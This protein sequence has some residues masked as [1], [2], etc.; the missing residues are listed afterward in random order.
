MECFEKKE[1]ITKILL[2]IR[3]GGGACN[4]H[5]EQVLGCNLS[6]EEAAVIVNQLKMLSSIPLDVVVDM[7]AEHLRTKL[8][9]ENSD[10]CEDQRNS[11][12]ELFES[13]ADGRNL[14]LKVRHN[15]GVLTPL[16][17]TVLKSAIESGRLSRLQALRCINNGVEITRKLEAD[18]S[19]SVPLRFYTVDYV[20]N[21]Q[22]RRDFDEVQFQDVVELSTPFKPF[23]LLLSNEIELRQA[24]HPELD[25]LNWLENSIQEESVLWDI[26]ANIGYYSLYAVCLQEKVK[27]VCFEPAPLNI[28]R[29]NLNIQV[30]GFQDIVKAFPIAISDSTGLNTFGSST[31]VP[32]AWSHEGIGSDNPESMDSRSDHV[33]YSGCVT[34]S[35]DDLLTG[36]GLASAPTHLKIDVDGP[37]LRI[38]QGAC[39]CLS[40]PGLRHILIELRTDTEAVEAQRILE[41]YGFELKN[42]SVSGFGNRIFEKNDSEKPVSGS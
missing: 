35:L 27:A 21:P 24:A 32:A 13:I 14:S 3:G 28:G 11:V 16:H 19:V 41:V 22:V 10:I 25:T 26:G 34:Y 39:N 5:I 36:L 17:E 6:E 9:D 29:L 37:E 40:L 38:L 1:E 7:V 2:E 42:S 4:H 23:K 18:S 30:N 15:F 12:S 8:Q 33:S 31:F 20:G